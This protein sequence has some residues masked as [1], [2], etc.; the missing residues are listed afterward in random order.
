MMLHGLANVKNPHM[1]EVRRKVISSGKKTNS[2]NQNGGLTVQNVELG[3]YTGQT[4]Y[5]NTLI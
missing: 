1:S 5:V 4:V 3:L 2:E